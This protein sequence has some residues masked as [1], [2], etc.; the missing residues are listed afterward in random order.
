MA[1]RWHDLPYSGTGQNMQDI[2]S[3]L[4]ARHLIRRSGKAC[5]AT[6]D[7][8]DG[9]PYASLVLFAPLAD[10][11]PVMMLSDLAEHT[12]NIRDCSTCSLMIDGTEGPAETMAGMRLTLQGHI[13]KI[14]NTDARQRLIRRHPETAVYAGFSDFNLYQIRPHRMHLIGGFG[15]IDWLDA[16]DVLA[17][18][19]ELDNA[20]G[21]IIGHMNTD[22]AD[23]VTA[24]ARARGRDDDN[25]RM[26][27]IDTDGIDLH[28]GGEYLRLQTE[29]RMMTPGDARRV[30]AALAKSSRQG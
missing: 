2:P 16:G 18:A 12:R 8:N 24:Y 13:S 27:G 17:S 28:N 22:H 23:A 7:R 10:A 4:H 3:S 11:S 29:E 15:M 19:P 9:A 20:A 21:E 25:W 5:L 6:I 30:L 14:E 26:T 1:R